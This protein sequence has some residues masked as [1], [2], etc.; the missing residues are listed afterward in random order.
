MTW[1]HIRPDRVGLAVVAIALLLPHSG[2]GQQPATRL[3]FAPVPGGRLEYEVRGQGEPVLL[4]HGA[5]IADLL[6]PLAA[7]P[8]LSRY[9]VIRL[10]RR[11]YAG[12]SAVGDSFS[13]EQDAADAAALLRHLGVARAHVVGHSSGGVVA[14][15]L[16]A[17]FPGMVQTLVLLDPPLSFTR[18]RTLQPR[19][20]GADSVEAFVLAKGGPDF[21]AQLQ[22]RIPGALQQARR[23]ERRFNVVEWTALGAWEFDEA[24]AR[25]ITVPILFVSQEHAAT[26]DTAKGWWPRME[27]V[28]LTGQTHMFP[29][30]APAATARAIA[31]FLA[32]H[33]M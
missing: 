6:L 27:F 29:F 7:Q 22:A 3:Q 12:S 32:R 24:K 18:A 17:A 10:H 28:E 20:G 13:I 14:M 4:I 21:R 15:E 26:V 16:A 2:T 11:G 1:P 8:A 31:G 30:E 5:M 19:T 9:Q 33:P 25:R 23:D